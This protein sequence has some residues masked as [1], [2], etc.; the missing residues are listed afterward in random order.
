MYIIGQKWKL[1]L[2]CLDVHIA[3]ACP[4]PQSAPP[5]GC[6]PVTGVAYCLLLAVAARFGSAKPPCEA[7]CSSCGGSWPPTC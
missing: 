6:L 7:C 5:C 4:C 2:S 1:L 3:C